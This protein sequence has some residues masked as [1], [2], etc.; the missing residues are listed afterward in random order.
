MFFFGPQMNFIFETVGLFL[1]VL[2]CSVRGQDVSGL[3][4]S[5]IRA[6]IKPVFGSLEQKSLLCL[7]D[8]LWC[9][10]EDAFR[11]TASRDTKWML[12]VMHFS[13]L[14]TRSTLNTGPK[15]K[16]SLYFLPK[17]QLIQ[18][19]IHRHK[20]LY[21]HVC[22]FELVTSSGRERERTVLCRLTRCVSMCVWWRMK[23]QSQ[24]HTRMSFQGSQTFW[25]LHH[26]ADSPVPSLLVRAPISH[27]RGPEFESHVVGSNRR[28]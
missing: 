8:K 23:V 22:H 1:G 18:T 17:L 27:A 21:K 7:N 2:V 5:Q 4:A 26:T 15:L 24:F 9:S 28:G 3:W 25:S 19:K 16:F 10:A 14:Y 6:L 12:A 13:H 11:Q 20:C